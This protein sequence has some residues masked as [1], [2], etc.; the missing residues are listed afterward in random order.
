[1]LKKRVL[2]KRR[3]KEKRRGKKEIAQ[4]VVA[5]SC[6]VLAAIC[7]STIITFFFQLLESIIHN[8]LTSTIPNVKTG[9]K[10]KPPLSKNIIFVLIVNM[11]IFVHPFKT[12]AST[13][14]IISK[15]KSSFE[16]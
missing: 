12:A 14:S 11:L 7:R 4:I 6:L 16:G 8:K 5:A 9:D 10:Y 2:P 1:M 15:P 13:A 3:E